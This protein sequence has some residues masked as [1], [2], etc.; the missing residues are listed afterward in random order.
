[1]RPLDRKLL[2]DLRRL[3]P[4]AAAIALLGAIGV[5]VAVMANSALKSVQVAEDRFYTDTRFGDVFATAE[6]APNELVTKLRAIDGVVAVDARASGG[7]LAPVP[8]LDRPAHATLIALPDQDAYALNRVVV[9]AGRMPERP[10]EAVALKAFLDAAHVSLGQRL[11]ATVN[12]RQVSL[13]IVGAGVSPEFVYSTS[14]TLL[15]DDAHEAVLWAPKATVEGAAGQVGAFARVSLKLSGDTLPEAVLP[16]VDRL[17]AP[18]GGTAAQARA[19]QPSN[20]FVTDSL[21]RLRL[22]SVILPPIFLVVAAALTHMVMAR[23]VETEREQIGLLK[24]FGF[25]NREVALPY[26]KLAAAIGVLG[27]LV[28]GL[29]GAGLA[30]GLTTIYAQ[31][32]RFPV[33]APQ[34]DW[35]VFALTGTVA[36]VAAV[37]GA[38]LSALRAA[39]LAPAVAMQPAAPVAYRRGFLDRLDLAARLDQPTRMILRRI[40]RFPGKTALTAGGLAL[41]LALL[42]STQFLQDA[43]DR[44]IDDAF[45]RAQRW[46]AQLTF[47]HPRDR[48]AIAEAVRLPGVVAAEPVRGAGAWAEGPAGRKQAGLIGID[49]GS[50]LVQPLDA[51]GRRLALMGRGVVLSSALAEHLGLR[52]GGF[53]DLDILEG[54]RPHLYLPITALADDYS[55]LNVY[56]DRRALNGLLGEGD[57]ASSANLV[58]APDATPRLY[59]ALVQIPQVIAASSRDDTVANWRA[60]TA[61]SFSIT[62][63]FYLTFSGAI[64]LGVAYNMGRI[65]LAER[66][67]DLATLQVLGFTR[68]EC[69]YI[70]YGELVAI[71]LIAL[72]F[73]TGL[74]TL[75]AQGLVKAFSRDELRLPVAITPRTMAVSISAY[76]GSVAIG[77]LMLQ[78]QLSRLDMV[79]VLKTRE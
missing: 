51:R 23:L 29:A 16:Q 20:K 7:G 50:T 10:N 8:G 19:D 24:A 48:S 67:R 38:S 77:C 35:G 44:V 22:L 45:F 31:Y 21:R 73:G 6:R 68:G 5:S 52:A 1:V 79:A 74:G 76:A 62:I 47:F 70:L 17:L 28:G 40:E 27:V 63:G 43:L 61:K 33:F 12:G 59:Q 3:A 36:V 75:M 32:F 66:S 37:A 78:R 41:S 69:A 58:A 60:T 11:T 13:A 72:P 71:A 57:L 14:S 2:R 53:V 42:V 30:A 25:T 64:A 54:K 18:Y 9:V 65:T 46:S 34:F 39:A 49:P 26:L 56:I 55:G 4:Q 15:P